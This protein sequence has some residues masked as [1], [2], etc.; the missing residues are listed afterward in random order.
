MNTFARSSRVYCG[1][2]SS[3]ASMIRRAVCER[4]PAR[5]RL[6]QA[7]DAFGKPVEG[8]AEADVA[9]ERERAAL[10]LGALRRQPAELAVAQTTERGAG[11]R[12][13]LTAKAASL[14]HGQASH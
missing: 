5:H 8:R 7:G 1:C 2:S 12:R 10:A 11:Q 9:H 13:L 14:P 4:R 6:P 3:I